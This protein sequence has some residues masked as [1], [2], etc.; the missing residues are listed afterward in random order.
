MK[1]FRYLKN[2]ATLEFRAGR[3]SRM[4]PMRGGLPDTRCSPSSKS[5][6]AS[7][8]GMPAWSAGPAP[9]T[10]R[11]PPSRSMRAWAAPPVSSGSG[12]GIAPAGSRRAPAAPEDFL[13]A[14][15]SPTALPGEV[16]ALSSSA[17]PLAEG[18]PVLYLIPAAP[19]AHHEAG[20]AFPW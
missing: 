19:R 6:S 11:L 3:V 5:R 16:P 1:H 10:A 4:R 7:W 9:G 17:G 14:P 2:V 8:T 13:P 15:S 20:A 12:S 18:H